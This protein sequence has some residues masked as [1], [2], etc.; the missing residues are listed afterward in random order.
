LWAF[1]KSSLGKDYEIP[2]SCLKNCTISE[3]CVTAQIRI[4]I[5]IIVPISLSAHPMFITPASIIA[6][7]GVDIN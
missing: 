6:L 5:T 4:A 3:I 1:N 7:T 2:G